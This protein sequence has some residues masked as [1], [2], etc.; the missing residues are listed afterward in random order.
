[1]ISS[2][3]SYFDIVPLAVFI[4]EASGAKEHFQET[5]VCHAHSVVYENCSDVRNVFLIVL[6]CEGNVRFVKAAMAY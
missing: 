3:V 2:R 4:C 5:A 1:M 6:F